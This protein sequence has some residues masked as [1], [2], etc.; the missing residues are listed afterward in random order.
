MINISIIDIRMILTLL[1][2]RFSPEIQPICE[3]AID[4]MI[5]YILYSVDNKNG[6]KEWDVPENYADK[7]LNLLFGDT[8]NFIG[9]F[10]YFLEI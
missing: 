1:R 6:F 3:T 9:E 8:N 4:K 10:K 2:I 5:K 7:L